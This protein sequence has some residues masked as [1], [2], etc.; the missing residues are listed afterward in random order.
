MTREEALTSLNLSPY[1]K[2]SINLDIE[3]VANKLEITLDEIKDL[4]ELPLKS[5]RDYKN[6]LAIFDIGAKV[7][8]KLGFEK[9]AIK[10]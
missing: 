8:Q 10:R 3:Y 9:Q 2:E 5:F 1:D 6:S 7:L 4:H